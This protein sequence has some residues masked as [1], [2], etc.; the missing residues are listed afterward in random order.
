METTEL[1]ITTNNEID[2]Q[3]FD[4]EIVLQPDAVE[5]VPENK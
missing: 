1:K 4:N 3:D 5:V 2:E